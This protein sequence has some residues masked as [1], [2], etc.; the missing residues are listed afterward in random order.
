MRETIPGWR[1]ADFLKQEARQVIRTMLFSL[2]QLKICSTVVRTT[3][4]DRVYICPEEHFQ[5]LQRFIP[6]PASFNYHK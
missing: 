1:M 3:Q 6:L 2:Y 4:T 5:Q